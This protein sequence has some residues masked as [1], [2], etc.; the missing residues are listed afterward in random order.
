MNRMD[1]DGESIGDSIGETLDFASICLDPNVG[2]DEFKSFNQC[3]ITAALA[4]AKKLSLVTKLWLKPT[5]LQEV[6]SL[7][8]QV[9]NNVPNIDFVLLVIPEDGEWTLICARSHNVDSFLL[10][11]IVRVRR[12]HLH[13]D[14]G[15]LGR[16]V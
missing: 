12:G 1:G 13:V 11:P 2:E 8:S 5:S 14:Q 10:R 7:F 3:F 15:H 9:R 16:A 4:L 6:K